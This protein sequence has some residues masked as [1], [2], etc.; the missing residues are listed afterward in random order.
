MDNRMD[1]YIEAMDGLSF[2]DEEKKRMALE[3]A[4]RVEEAQH[5]RPA[6][7]VQMPK[8]RARW[9]FRAVAAAALI[10][11]L[12]FGGTLAYADGNLDV[13]MGY[14]KD[15]FTGAPADTEVV[16]MVGCPLEATDTCNG[17]RITA[18]AVYGDRYNYTA[19]FSI[20]REDGSPL[21]IEGVPVK[22][23][24]PL[25]LM[26]EAGADLH[27][28]G[29]MGSAGSSYFYDADPTDNAIQYVAQ[30]SVDV[31][32]DGGIV[33]RTARIEFGNL[34]TVGSQ[35]DAPQVVLKGSWDLKF[36]MN[37]Q[38]S[39]VLL[40]ASAPLDAKTEQGKDVK[41]VQVAVSSLGISVDYTIG[42]QWVSP[43][44]NGKMDDEAGKAF[45]A[46]AGLPVIVTFSDGTTFDATNS[47]VFIENNEAGGSSVRKSSIFDRIVDT[48]DI[49]YVTI[50][51]TVIEVSPAG[52]SP[53]A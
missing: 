17:V 26:F 14:V 18:D 48:S 41:L 32:E 44:Q 49:A 39:T 16:G 27:I 38:D 42:E 11:A 29:M 40:L 7:V 23:D 43:K 2:S 24:E 34:L 15:L 31:P 28:D 45:D 4:K 33:G 46:I 12:G 9:P 35:Y 21:G 19:V 25:G 37:F 3:I 50:G 5:S 8:R 22:S 6:Q 47:S 36:K 30:L 20:E 51:G 52:T 1:E 10:A 13:A 53:T